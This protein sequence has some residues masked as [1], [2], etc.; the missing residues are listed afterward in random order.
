GVAEHYSS[1]RAGRRRA[2]D[3]PGKTLPHQVRQVAAMID[4]RMAEHHRVDF[5]WWKREFLIASSALGPRSLKQAAVQQQRLPHRV[6]A[7][8]RTGDAPGSAPK[9]DHRAG[10]L[11]EVL[12]HWAIVPPRPHL[13]VTTPAIHA[14]TRATRS[15]SRV[16][17]ANFFLHGR[18]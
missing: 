4:V 17:R 10:V 1:Q 5:L 13:T 6:H 7:V 18:G 9:R 15:S 16:R 3:R 2:I 12:T 14:K 8:H 11:F